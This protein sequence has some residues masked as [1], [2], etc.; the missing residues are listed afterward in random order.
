[1]WKA[2]ANKTKGSYREIK[3]RT[4]QRTK[5]IIRKQRGHWGWKRKQINK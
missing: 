2:K 1:M 5:E 4:T 3:E